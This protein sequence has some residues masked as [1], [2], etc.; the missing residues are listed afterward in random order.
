MSSS[1]LVACRFGPP[2][3][4]RSITL[5]LEAWRLRLV[6]FTARFNFKLCVLLKADGIYLSSYNKSLRN[7]YVIFLTFSSKFSFFE[8]LK[9]SKQMGS[10]FLI[11]ALLKKHP[12]RNNIPANIAL[13]LYI[14]V[15][16]YKYVRHIKVIYNFKSVILKFGI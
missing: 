15:I 5:M 13:I 3:P 4:L 6:Y 16:I 11:L 10:P 2:L 1:L 12:I 8:K 9:C 7:L 14:I